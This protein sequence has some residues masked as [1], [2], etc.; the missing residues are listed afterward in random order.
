MAALM[1]ISAA[2]PEFGS[3]PAAPEKERAGS[4]SVDDMPPVQ[5]VAAHIRKMATEVPAQ[6][7]GGAP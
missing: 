4:P 5:V 6:I 1:P 7:W 2:S 3:Q